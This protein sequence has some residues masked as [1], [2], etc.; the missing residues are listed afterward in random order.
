MASTE[1]RSPSLLELKLAIRAA[2]PDGASLETVAGLLDM[3][4]RTLQRRLTGH[5]LTLSQAVSRVRRERA[6]EL[7][8]ERSLSITQIAHRVGFANPSSFSRAFHAWT[9][10][11]PRD[12]RQAQRAGAI[13][14]VPARHVIG[15][16]QDP[17]LDPTEPVG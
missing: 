4:P 7:L 12:Y 17:T 5:G 8:G 10:I 6:V 1:P 9:G 14:E 3:S 2:L 16:G 11:C 15:G 13:G